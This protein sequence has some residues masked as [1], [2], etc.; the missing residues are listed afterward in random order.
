MRSARRAVD[1]SPIR[2]AR[3]AALLAAV[4]LA[5]APAAL[6][7]DEPPA[8]IALFDGESLDGWEPTEFSHPGEVRVD[9]GA[10]V[11]AAGR[12]MTGI[13]ST[14]D[15]LPRVDYELSFEAKRLE[16]RDFFAAA[17]FPVGD[18]YITLVNGGWGGNVTGLSS[19]DGAD[20][21]E[22]ETSKYYKYEN[23]RWYRFRVRVT[24]SH[25]ACWVDDAPVV[26][27]DYTGRQVKTR[28]ET[29][30]NQPLGFCTWE[31]SGSVRKV[32]VRRLTPPE[33][34]ETDALSP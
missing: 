26:A 23:D 34:A 10:I 28:P 25:I 7:D 22:N 4:L 30:G 32:T 1:A 9:D 3:R 5:V 13:T 19:L 27:V 12:P 6:A 33:I 16:G 21:S 11:L 20:A 14:R 15:D 24:P 18:S 8:P 17:T 29:R 31:T 2:L